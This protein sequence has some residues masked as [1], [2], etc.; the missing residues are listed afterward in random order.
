LESPSVAEREGV[1]SRSLTRKEF[2]A[3]GLRGLGAGATVMLVGCPA[4]DDT[5]DGGTET[6]LANETTGSAETMPPL[7]TTVAETTEAAETTAADDAVT[8]GT[9]ETGTGTETEGAPACASVQAE[10]G[11]PSAGPEHDH[12]VEVPAADVVAGREATYMLSFDLGHLHEITVTTPMFA[13]LAQGEPV[14]VETGLDAT[15]HAHAVTLVCQ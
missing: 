11:P 4:D 7:E 12:V 14:V 9:A 15:A 13:L 3:L 1:M 10:V 8:D 5:V 6:T 2:V